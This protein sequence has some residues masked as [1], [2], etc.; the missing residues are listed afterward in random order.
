MGGGI[1]YFKEG[2]QY[3]ELSLKN[4]H[5]EV[6]GLWVWVRDWGNK[7]TFVVGVCY[8]LPDQAEPIEAFFL[9]L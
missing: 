1:L 3:E 8:R 4:N 6:E 9:L 5:E 2:V 7:G